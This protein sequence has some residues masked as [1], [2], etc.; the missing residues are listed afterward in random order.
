MN[1]NIKPAFVT[2]TVYPN[3]WLFPQSEL[4]SR[5][6]LTVGKNGGKPRAS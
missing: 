4:W 6:H 1:P 5:R 2:A 3:S